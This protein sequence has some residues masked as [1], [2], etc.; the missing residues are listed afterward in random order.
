MKNFKYLAALQKTLV[1]YSRRRA[2]GL[3]DSA[4]AV[5]GWDSV[6]KESL[7]PARK[8]PSSGCQ[9]FGARRRKL[10]ILA[11]VSTF[12]KSHFHAHQILNS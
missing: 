3:Q 9:E 5:G 4:H 8:L 12:F 6:R 1:H 10:G 11:R 2:R 7:V